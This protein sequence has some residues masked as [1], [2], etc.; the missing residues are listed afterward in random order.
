MAADTTNFH[1]ENWPGFPSISP[2]LTF[3]GRII[4]AAMT[5]IRMA[6]RNS[7]FLPST[8]LPRVEPI[9]AAMAPTMAKITASF[10]RTLPA[11]ACGIRFK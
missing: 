5:S 7:S 3:F 11:R 4:K 1:I 6:K 9:Y 8:A 2:G 10:Q